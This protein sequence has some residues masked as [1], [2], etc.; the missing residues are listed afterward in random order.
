MPSRPPRAALGAKG[1]CECLC[2]LVS[3]PA[4]VHALTLPQGLAQ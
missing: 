3:F 4:N 1:R 2:V